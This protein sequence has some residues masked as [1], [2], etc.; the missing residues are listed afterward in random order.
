MQELETGRNRLIS[1][2]ADGV[3]PSFPEALSHEVDHYF[4][5]RVKEIEI[6]GSLPSAPMALVAVGGYGRGVLCPGSDI[7]VMVLFSGKLPAEAKR[8]R[9]RCCIRSGTSA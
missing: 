4:V 2:L 6:E 8:S 9:P 1:R 5:E 7:D 3:S